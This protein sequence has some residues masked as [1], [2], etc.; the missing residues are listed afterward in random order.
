MLPPELT[1]ANVMKTTFE[2]LV[3][4]AQ[5]LWV[6]LIKPYPVFWMIVAAIWLLMRLLPAPRRR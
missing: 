1:V 5:M 2:F 3:G 4:F 6:A